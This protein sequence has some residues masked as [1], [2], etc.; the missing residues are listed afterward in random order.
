MYIREL[1]HA[2]VY[3]H[4]GSYKISIKRLPLFN[5]ATSPAPTIDASLG[6]GMVGGVKQ[7]LLIFAAVALVGCGKEE[8]P[9]PQEK[10]KGPSKPAVPDSKKDRLKPPSKMEDPLPPMIEPKADLTKHER[11]LWRFEAGGKMESSPAIGSDGVVFI[12]SYA[13][14]SKSGAKKW[15]FETGGPVW[16]SPAIGS[17]GTIYVGSRDNKLHALNGRS[18]AKNWEFETGGEVDSS[19]V[20]GSDG[21]VYIGSSD[22]KVYA[23]KTASKGPAKSPW[24]MRGQNARHTGRVMKK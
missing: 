4:S 15:E 13:L 8:T 22:K 16:S 23:L 19:P 11:F 18:G 21:T 12:G 3:I 9:K 14:D 10:A 2:H 1:Q 20:I 5:I 24:P 17:D 7:L 6:V